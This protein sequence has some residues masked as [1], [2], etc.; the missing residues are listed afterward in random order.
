M[1]IR[2]WMKHKGNID[3]GWMSYFEIKPEQIPEMVYIRDRDKEPFRNYIQEGN[4]LYSG[5]MNNTGMIDIEKKEIYESDILEMWVNPNRKGI[6]KVVF[7]DG[8]YCAET[9]YGS[10]VA[11][12]KFKLAEYG[13]FCVLIKVIGY[14]YRNPELLKDVK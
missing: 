5:I 10:F 7:A 12:H 2:I 8:C 14:I 3:N 9:L 4:V 6:A 1:T 13:G 11:G